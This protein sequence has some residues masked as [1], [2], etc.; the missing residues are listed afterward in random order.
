MKR[1]GIIRYDGYCQLCSAT[2]RWVIRRDRKKR[3]SFRP[4]EDGA[5]DSDTV[6]LEEDGKLYERSTAVLRIASGLPFPWPLLG[7]FFLIPRR[8]RDALYDWVARNRKKWFG[9]R[10][11]CYIP[12]DQGQPQ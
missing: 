3:F 8:I 6:L 5:S 12:G 10:S 2:V 4:L 1:S 11:T 7:V 9:T